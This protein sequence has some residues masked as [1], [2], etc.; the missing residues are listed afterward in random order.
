LPYADI[1]LPIPVGRT[2][3]YKVPDDRSVQVGSRVIVQFGPKKI[4]TGLVANVKNEP[5][6]VDQSKEIIEVLD[7]LPIVNRI[8][9]GFFGWMANYYMCSIGEVMNAAIPAGLKLTSDAFVSLN[10]Q[11]QWL[12]QPQ[13]E[14]EDI[15]VAQLAD[16]E[17]SLKEIGDLIDS[18]Y[19]QRVVKSMAD[20]NIVHLFEKVK[21][22]YAPKYVRKV[23]LTQTFEDQEA[24]QLLFEEL[25]KKPKQLDV[26]LAYL[27]TVPA[28]ESAAAN[29]KGM[30]KSQLVLD[31]GNSSLNTL[32]K[33]EIFEE[34]DHLISRLPEITSDEVIA[35][36]LSD[37]QSLTRQQILNEFEKHSTVLLRGITGSG[38]TEIY[39]S[40]IQEAL[41]QGNQVLYLLPEIALTTQIIKRLQLVFG[42]SFGVYHSHYSDNERVEIW[43][44]VLSGA[45][46]FVVGVRSS[47]FLPFSNLGLVIVDEEHESSYKQFDP[48]PR[49]N[50]RDAAIYLAGKHG[51]KVLLGSATPA[52]E[53][54][55]KALDGKFGLVELDVRFGDVNLP[56]VELIDMRLVRK[57]KELKA[58]IFS[59]ELLESIGAALEKKEQVILFQNRRGYAPFVSCDDCGHVMN[60][61]N[62]DVSLTYHQFQNKLICHYCGHNIYMPQECPECNNNH[63]MHSGFGTEQLEDELQPFFPEAKI[64]RMDLDTTRNK[65]SYSRILDDFEEGQTDVLVGTQMVSKGLDFDKVNLVGVFDIDRIIHFPDFRS[66]ER[67]YQLITQVSGRS[68]RKS[69][70]GR[71][72]IQTFDPTHAVLQQVLKEEYRPFYQ[73]EIS[74]REEYLYPPY[75]RI[76]KIVLKHKEAQIVNEGAIFFGNLLRQHLGNERVNGPVDP[77]I[78]RLRNLYL[79]EIQ[80]KIERGGPPLN[81]VKEVILSLNDE[82]LAQKAFKSVRVVFDVDPI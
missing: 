29:H 30:I 59:T 44:K 5:P 67:A 66:H 72:L 36:T 49:Y 68:G 75:S 69:G 10:P 40:L 52:V 45:Y 43:Q 9:I 21:D 81:G 61:P 48:A 19:P 34:W 39:V 60:C 3:T 1:I 76:I 73:T 54:F 15:V 63:M 38:K 27:R 13:N 70:E 12:D 16:K 56:K 32:I 35:P 8:Q 82:L 28:M 7:D 78:H 71:V 2:Y 62:C 22:K 65:N 58:N 80:I 55:S 47:V 14:K 26:L 20:R 51:A 64:Q 6:L 33:K 53:T 57:R 11:G 24:L 18:K 41:K 79:K 23:R 74:E 42:N 77:V 50:A 25:D 46:S 4:Y 17:L 37:L 31:S